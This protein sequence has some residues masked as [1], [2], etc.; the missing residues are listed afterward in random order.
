MTN[1]IAAK[2]LTGPFNGEDVLKSTNTYDS[3]RYAISI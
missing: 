3:N 2:I 1:I